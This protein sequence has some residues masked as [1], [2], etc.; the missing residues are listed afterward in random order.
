MTLNVIPKPNK[1]SYYG[2]TLNSDEV[3]IAY[4]TDEKLSDEGYVISIQQSGIT[5]TSKSEK[6]KFYADK[7]LSQ[8]LRQGSVPLCRIEDEP[9]FPYRG[10]MIDS[11][12]HMQS[13]EEIKKYISAAAELKFNTFHCVNLIGIINIINLIFCS[14]FKTV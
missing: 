3:G 2:G 10:F 12:R 11:V 6:G 7:T 5:I 8:I 9:A 1:V 4:L 13:V 14:C